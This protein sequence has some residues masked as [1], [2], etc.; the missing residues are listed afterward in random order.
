MRMNGSSGKFFPDNL[1]RVQPVEIRQ[2]I[3]RQHQ[4]PFAFAQRLDKFVAPADVADFRCQPVVGKLVAHQQRVRRII[5]QM[6]Y[7][8]R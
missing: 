1:E 3:I 2:A 5:F 4:I 7:A 8:E 6:Q